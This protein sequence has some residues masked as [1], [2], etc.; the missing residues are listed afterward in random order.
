MNNHDLCRSF[1]NEKVA[2]AE[3]MVRERYISL[4]SAPTTAAI[5]AADH[6]PE[7]LEIWRRGLR[8]IDELWVVGEF[9]ETFKSAVLETVR[10]WL[11]MCKR[12]DAA[13]RMEAL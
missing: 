3:K 8:N 10:T 2:Q 1:F 9:G 11:E 4:Q 5:W 6:A 7:L 13:L 12:Y